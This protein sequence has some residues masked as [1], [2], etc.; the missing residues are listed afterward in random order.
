MPLMIIN[1]IT[2]QFV[3]PFLL[4]YIKIKKNIKSKTHMKFIWINEWLIMIQKI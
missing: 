4:K 2:F 3:F 1:F